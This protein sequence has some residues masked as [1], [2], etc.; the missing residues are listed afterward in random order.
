[1]KIKIA[2]IALASLIFPALN[3]SNASADSLNV[4][5]GIVSWPD[6]MYVAT[7]CSK[8]GFEYSNG[9]GVELL[10]LGF[11]LTDPFGG[12]VA[13]NSQIGIKPGITGS[14]DTQIC[15][16]HFTNGNGPYIMK[17]TVKDFAGTA[18]SLTKEIMF[19][20]SPNAKPTASPKLPAP[21]PTVT[22]TATPE[23]APTVYLTNPEDDTLRELV[24][25]L[26]SQVSMLNSKV[27]KICSAKPKP[28]GC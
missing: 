17:V 10:S 20:T 23:P 24:K 14:W 27:K 16:F 15:S 25:S 4:L 3:A 9:T 12:S 18:K 21:T 6:K 22:V 11:N 8:Y 19:L 26:Q 7:G 1:M 13:Y 28:K 2:L 5:G